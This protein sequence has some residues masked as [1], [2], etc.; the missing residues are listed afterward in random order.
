MIFR[1]KL[2]RVLALLAL[3]TFVGAG[4]ARAAT[5]DFQTGVASFGGTITNVGSF[6]YG[7]GIPL[8]LMNVVGVSATAD[9]SYDLSGTGSYSNFSGTFTNCCAVLNFDSELNTISVVG[10]VPT[11]SVPDGT[12]LLQGTITS[13]TPTVG[14]GFF[15]ALATGVD[16]KSPL[17]L[18]QLGLDPNTQF[19]F[20]GFTIALQTST[21]P[22]TYTAISTDI[23]NQSIP[24]PGL[25]ALF[26]L[27]L[28]GV[29]HRLARRRA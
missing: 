10:G 26:G 6:W 17:L 27:G 28:L 22:N 25:L 23:V 14:G 7:T 8:D 2:T 15:G 19:E 11:L 24:E 21:Q 1:I 4:S 3:T 16:W 5:I 20:F 9:G 13:F 12:T 29:G 18:T